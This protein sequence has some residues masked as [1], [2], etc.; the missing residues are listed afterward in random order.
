MFKDEQFK[1]ILSVKQFLENNLQKLPENYSKISSIQKEFYE[2]NL[3]NFQIFLISK[4][5]LNWKI[6]MTENEILTLIHPYFFNI[7]P[8]KTLIS[9]IQSLENVS[10]EDEKKKEFGN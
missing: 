9:L 4:I 5:L 1:D 10:I 3:Q 7:F 6:F 8:L 2:K